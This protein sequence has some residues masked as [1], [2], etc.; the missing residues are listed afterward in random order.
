ML[1]RTLGRM[2]T[3][4]ASVDSS[5]GTLSQVLH[6]RALYDELVVT[7]K[8]TRELLNDVKKNPRR[9]FKVSVF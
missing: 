4:I 3:M 9:Y 2:D 5:Q 8:D 6:D 1:Q 7:V